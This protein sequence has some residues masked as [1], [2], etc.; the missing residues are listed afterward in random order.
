LVLQCLQRLSLWG[1][2]MEKSAIFFLLAL[3]FHRVSPYGSTGAVDPLLL[4]LRHLQ[5]QY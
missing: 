2:K 4:A 1:C 3:P 5:H